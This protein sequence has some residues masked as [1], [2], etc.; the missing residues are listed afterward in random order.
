ML[1]L[2][3]NN[4]NDKKSSLVKLNRRVRSARIPHLVNESFIAALHTELTCCHDPASSYFWLLYG[5]ITEAALL[6]AGHYADNCE[7]SAAGDLLVNPRRIRVS[8]QDSSLS[9][10]KN[11]HGS[12]SKQFKPAG[13][14]PEQFRKRFSCCMKVRIEQA[15]LLPW[16]SSAL[17]QSGV[18]LESYIHTLNQRMK[19]IADTMAFLSAWSLDN[20]LELHKRLA[21]ATS[22][23][24]RFIKRNL[25]GFKPAEFDALGIEL[26]CMERNHPTISAF[27]KIGSGS[28][29][30]PA[31][32][33]ERVHK[34]IFR[35]RHR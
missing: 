21:S 18:F 10:L 1:Q 8:G 5:R 29:W 7:Y 19:K 31:D 2:G 27:L 28:V 25:C 20:T 34:H 11:R 22:D 26:D 17:E 35:T 3:Q 15:A 30:N 4:N 33:D 32:D 9:E 24:R 12:I 14:S 16:M 6:C 13:M 23:S